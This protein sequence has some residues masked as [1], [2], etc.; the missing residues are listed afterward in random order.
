MIVI[1]SGP[2]LREPQSLVAQLESSLWLL[3]PSDGSYRE[4]RE[5]KSLLGDEERERVH[6]AIEAVLLRQGDTR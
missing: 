6:V 3:E 1:K 5:V 2:L 4:G